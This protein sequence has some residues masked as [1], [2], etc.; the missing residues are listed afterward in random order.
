M[1]VKIYTVNDCNACEVLRDALEQC[2]ISFTEVKVCR[3]LWTLSCGGLC[4][5]NKR[6]QRRP[7]AM[8]IHI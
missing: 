2:N 3:L 6:K 8:H 5:K 7:G 1:D 4:C